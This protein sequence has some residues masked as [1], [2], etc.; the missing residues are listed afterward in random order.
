MVILGFVL[1]CQWFYRISKEPSNNSSDTSTKGPRAQ[2]AHTGRGYKGATEL[3]LLTFFV[4]AMPVG[5]FLPCRSDL[6]LVPTNPSRDRTAGPVL[7]HAYI[8]NIWWISSC[9]SN[10]VYVRMMP[11]YIFIRQLSVA[12]SVE[13]EEGKLEI[14]TVLTSIMTSRLGAELTRAWW[15]TRHIHACIVQNRWLT[16]YS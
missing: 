2:R 9:Y 16:H 10:D 8:V 7:R 12:V 3:L 14:G 11:R 15:T 1:L 6:C 4:W 5:S 13:G